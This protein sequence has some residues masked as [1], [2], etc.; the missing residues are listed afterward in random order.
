MDIRHLR[1]FIAVA[2]KLHFGEAARALNMTQPPLS[3]R[4]AELEE[5]LGAP[6]FTRTSRKVA[7]T[8]A[9]RALLP[10]ARAAL[11]AFDVALASVRKKQTTG[12]RVRAGFPAD[13][14]RRVLGS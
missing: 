8:A 12:R 5:H 13:T 2:E 10:K 6:L 14:S 11:R 9:G 7:L 1:Y 3:K 4:I